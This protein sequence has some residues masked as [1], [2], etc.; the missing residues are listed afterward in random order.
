MKIKTYWR[1]PVTSPPDFNNLL[2]VLRRERPTRPTLFEFFL[3]TPLYR[4]TAGRAAEATL[5]AG[6]TDWLDLTIHSFRNAGYDYVNVQGSTFNLPKGERHKEKSVSLNEGMVITDRATFNAYQWP[7]PGAFDYSWLKTRGERLPQGMKFIVWGPGGVL[8]NVIGLT[9][10]DNLCFMLA[11]DRGLVRELFDAVGS[12]FVRYY[13]CCVGYDSVGALISNDDWGFKSQTML[14]PEA[15]REFVFPWHTKIVEVAHRAGKPII[16]H[17]CGNLREVMDDVIDV[18]GY[19]AK[20]SYED[21]IMPVEEAYEQYGRRI[22]IMGG[23]DVDFVCRATPQDVY[24][25]GKAMLE[26]TAARGGYA[27][28]TGNSVPE[29]VPDEKYFAMTSAVLA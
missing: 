4:L 27:L 23:M 14:A 20:H 11:D 15:M 21:T 22:A 16:L 12:R 2:K 3:N 7:D 24:R 10:Y 25:R 28:G 8:E 13:E 17:S 19:D 6:T 1:G 9:G 26:R 5:D 29:Y 18:M